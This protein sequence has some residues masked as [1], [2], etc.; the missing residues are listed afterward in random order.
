MIVPK[1]FNLPDHSR[2]VFEI[3]PT[4]IVLPSIASHKFNMEA[5]M[6]PFCIKFLLSL[7]FYAIVVY[8][9][10]QEILEYRSNGLGNY[11]KLTFNYP[12]LIF[13]IV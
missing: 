11:L 8:Y 9:T 2:I 4:G 6:Y 5:F 3:L 12:D 7:V 13:L 1:P 10:Y